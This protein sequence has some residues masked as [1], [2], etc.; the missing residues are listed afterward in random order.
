MC[1]RPH[2]HLGP[3]A[4]SHAGHVLLTNTQGIGGHPCPGPP[5]RSP[6]S[7]E[8]LGKV[9]NGNK[10]SGGAAGR[11]ERSRRLSADPAPAAPAPAPASSRRPHPLLPTSALPG[12]APR[13]TWSWLRGGKAISV[14]APVLTPL[15]APAKASRGRVGAHALCPSVTVGSCVL[16]PWGWSPGEGWSVL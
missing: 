7:Q 11:G 6:G 9:L 15:P 1:P 10:R 3:C 16:S 5:G 12:S 8:V 2:H 13:C 14:S 4:L